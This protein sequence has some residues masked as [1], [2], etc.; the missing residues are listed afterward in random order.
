MWVD[1]YFHY[2]DWEQAQREV[3]DNFNLLMVPRKEGEFKYFYDRG[4]NQ[5]IIPQGIF[6]PPNSKRALL[7]PPVNLYAGEL[8]ELQEKGNDSVTLFEKDPMRYM[9]LKEEHRSSQLKDVTKDVA[10]M[11]SLQNLKQGLKSDYSDKQIVDLMLG[12]SKFTDALIQEH[13]RKTRPRK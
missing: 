11:T 9:V 7:K 2:K 8:H 10:F 5:R 12:N 3:Y 6:P 13:L 1:D 4:T